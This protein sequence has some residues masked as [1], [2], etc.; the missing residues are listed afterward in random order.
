MDEFPSNSQNPRPAQPEKP[1]EKVVTKI[2]EGTVSRRKKPLGARLREMFFADSEVSVLDYVMGEVLV[3]AF[4]DMVTDAVSQ[5]FERMIY[6]ETRPGRRR[7]NSSSSG[8]FGSNPN[9]VDYSRYSSSRRDDRP[10]RRSRSSHEF[11]EIV[12]SSRSE[13]QDVIDSLIN[14]IQKYGRTSVADLYE[15]VGETPHHT[16][17]K[18]GWTDLDDARVRRVG[19]DSYLLDLPKNEPID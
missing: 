6:G 14:Y 13:A 4:K 8:A 7:P 5:G 12:L 2:V 1:P 15:L 3:P 17:S 16:D 9:R 10:V 18:W 11:D 19:N